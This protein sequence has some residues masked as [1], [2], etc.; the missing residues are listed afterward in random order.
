V[1]LFA[2]VFVAG[3]RPGAPIASSSAGPASVPNVA[4]QRLATAESNLAAAGFRAVKPVDDTGRNRVVIDPENWVVDSQT[5]KAGTHASTRTTVTLDVRRPSDGSGST[6][7]TNGVVPNVV[8]MNLQDAQDLLQAA[9]FVNLS[10]ID[11]NGQDRMQV[12][13]RSWL[14]TKQSIAAGTHLD[15]STR[16]ALTVVKYGE[17]TGSSGCKS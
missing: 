17:P 6:R 16:I 8:C 2:L 15:P 3:C 12:L 4:G 13:D 9:G 7:V 14:V 5:P 10:S 1:A 11:G